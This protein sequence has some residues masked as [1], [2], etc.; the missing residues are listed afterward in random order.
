MSCACFR[1]TSG[2]LSDGLYV[3]ISLTKKQTMKILTDAI[4]M[5]NATMVELGTF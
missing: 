4:M 2:S 3:R 1:A 5:N